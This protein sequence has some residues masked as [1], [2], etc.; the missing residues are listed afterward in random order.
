M[1]L[2]GVSQYKLV[3]TQFMVRCL[4]ISKTQLTSLVMGPIGAAHFLA[5]KNGLSQISLQSAISA[6]KTHPNMT[7]AR[8]AQTQYH[9]TV[10]V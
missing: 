3:F 2:D 7:K 6:F 8:R 9:G 1:H 10:I 4:H 5:R